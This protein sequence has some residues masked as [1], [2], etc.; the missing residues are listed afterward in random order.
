L[1]N[2]TQA[3]IAARWFPDQTPWLEVATENPLAHK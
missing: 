3:F 1:S 2:K